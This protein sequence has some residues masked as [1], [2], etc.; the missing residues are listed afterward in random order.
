[1]I[2]YNR[3]DALKRLL[4]SLDEAIYPEDMDVPLV[5][6]IDKSDSDGVI[7]AAEEFEWKHGTKEVRAQ[8]EN[9]GLKKHVLLCGDISGEFGSC[10]LLEDDLYVSKAFYIYALKALEKCREDDRIGGISLYDHRLNVHVREPFEAIDDGYDN[11]YIQMASSWGQAFN[12]DQWSAF[13]EWYEEHG[14]EPVEAVNVPENVSSW[15]ERSWLKYYIKYLIVTDRFFLY[16]RR[17][18]TTNFGD[19][20]TH[21]ERSVNDLQ[22]SLAGDLLKREYCFSTLCESRSVYDIYFENLSLAGEL[23]EKLGNEVTVD[24]YGLKQEGLCKRYLLSSKALPFK[25]IS[26]FGRRMR[27]VDANIVHGIEGDAFFLYDTEEAGVRP[28]VDETGKYLYDY[29][30]LKAKEMLSILGF[31]IREK[32]KEGF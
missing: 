22:V 18:L 30:A 5:I 28:K 21:A 19:E 31:R 7:R 32:F 14:G 13:K 12:R 16:P 8:K 11:Y 2:A 17:S 26:S 1:M 15:S 24:L 27:P 23:A 3:K 6:S 9:L 20:G 4:K 29:R 25:I 10:I